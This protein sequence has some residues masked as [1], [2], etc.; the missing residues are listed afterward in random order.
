MSSDR[1]ANSSS[2]EE[3]LAELGHASD[4]L[5]AMPR[6]IELCRRAL[7][8]VDRETQPELWARL[9]CELGLC[10]CQTP[11][12]DR[13]Q[14]LWKAVDHFLAALEVYTRHCFPE[15]WAAVQ[16]NL[17]IAYA[18][19]P[20]DVR[21]D[22]LER[23]IEHY[24]AALEVYTPRDFPQEWGAI[25]N[26][27][28]NVYAQCIEGERASN[29]AEAIRCYERA[30]EVWTREKN[31]LEWAL[32]QSN[33]GTAY[34]QLPGDDAVKNWQRA[35]ACYKEALTV[36]TRKEHP[37]RWAEVQDNLGT[38]WKNCPSGNR[39]ENLEQAIAYYE[40][41]LKVLE[42]HTAP[43]LRARV[44]HNLG[45]AL[46]SRICG[47]RAENLEQAIELFQA[48]L[49]VRTRKAHPEAWAQ[50]IHSL[51]HVYCE[52][53]RGNHAENLEEAI[54]LYHEALEVRTREDFPTAWATTWNDL[55]NAYTRRIRG[56]R[57]DNLE[58]A[59]EHYKQ[60]LEVRTREDC[61]TEWAK[62]QHNLAAAYQERLRGARAGNLTQAVMH[63]H[64]ALKVYT[65]QIS[66]MKWATVQNDLA[67]A[68][69]KLGNYKRAEEELE[70][71]AEYLEKSIAC[72]ENALRVFIRSDFPVKWAQ[73]HNNLAN[74]YCD[75]LRGDR[76]E[77][78]EK[79]IEFYQSTLTVRTK[80][81]LPVQWAQTQNNLGTAYQE[82]V[83]GNRKENLETAVRCFHQALEVHSP[84]A[85]PVDARRAARNLGNLHFEEGR[86]SQARDAYTTA[87]RAAEILY[88]A[89]YSPGGKEAEI[90]ENTALYERM[91]RVC[92]EESDYA[93]ALVAAEGSKARTFLDQM[94]QGAFP[95]PSGLPADLLQREQES[96]EKLRGQE[97]N[98]AGLLAGQGAGA[99]GGWEASHERDIIEQRRETLAALEA[100]W[101]EMAR[102]YPAAR[103][104]VAM[105][106][107]EPMTWDDLCGLAER[108]GPEAALVEFYTL[109]EEV[110]VFVLRAGWEAPRVHRAL[111]SYQ[112]L[113][114]RY[115]LP[116]R[117]EVIN[118]ESGQ[119]LT[120]DWLSLGEHLL[121]PLEHLLGDAMLVYFVPHGM[122]HYL[123]LHALTVA[124]EP[125]IVRWAVAY[126]P[127]AAVLA[128][129]LESPPAS[130]PELAEGGGS[131]ALVMGYTHREEERA[132]FEGEA[133]AIAV[134][135][136]T[137]PLLG[138]EANAE[139]LSQRGPG[140]QVIHLSCH[141][142]FHADDPATSCVRLAS[143][144]FTTRDWM[145][146]SL[147]ADLVALSACETGRVEVKPGDD[148]TGLTRALLY[149]GA[150]SALVTL[151]SVRADTTL[152]WMLDFYGR[153]WDVQGDKKTTEAF[154]FQQATLDLRKRYPD[155]YYWA[156]FALVGDWR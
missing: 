30:L 98:L 11:R 92:L 21:R 109:P 123:P 15:E 6:R 119:T 120:H 115:L 50:T 114:N 76:V 26:N 107:G 72:Y 151:W 5:T 34:L 65:D 44:Q 14:N 74:A 36:C 140:A 89:S 150:S 64:E 55:G 135:L 67:N 56:D 104:Y 73:A 99:G 154:A 132:L 70:L 141:G 68:Y 52:R 17:A 134:H 29:L 69:W 110:V 18:E 125:F 19:S 37:R 35:L 155:P 106:R 156:P 22:N 153:T 100:V 102:D 112:K 148:L 143:G 108:L 83:C 88:R 147:R 131:S 61:P 105:R 4:G 130:C 49:K 101:D 82:R 1:Q 23:A 122:L 75:R 57:A 87:I 32:A 39:A 27:L 103:S 8:Q 94:G 62:T 118:H 136:R 139:T 121:A 9:Q 38:A 85:F 24:R 93:A 46:E 133:Q 80:D 126:T 41:A 31:P 12:G 142:H 117:D 97:Q 58:R 137:S 59:I 84:Q 47:D 53:I 79:A 43:L 33:L 91:V 128:C 63:Y 25:Q 129:T 66:P 10:L 54:R 42:H 81:A 7:D 45:A 13:A 78:L 146:L 48:A 138:G 144:E 124:G 86:W 152:E 60:A 3:L 20:K 40:A 113:L 96:I 71:A 90:A 2:L 127:S 95:P 51:A 16:H 111:L 149:A 116:Y 77:N 145:S 28:G